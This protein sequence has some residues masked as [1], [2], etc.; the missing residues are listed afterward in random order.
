MGL[1][2]IKRKQRISA[3][4]QNTTWGGDK[5][6]FGYRMLCKM[7]WNEGQGLGKNQDGLTDHLRVQT[8][9]D[10]AGLGAERK[11]AVSAG[12]TYYQLNLFDD[13][14]RR[15]NGTDGEVNNDAREDEQL[16]EK[17]LKE[18]KGRERPEKRRSKAKDRRERS[19]SPSH[20]N[21]IMETAKLSK[22]SASSST[23]PAS[24]RLA[25][26]RKFIQQKLVASYSAMDLRQI[27][28]AQASEG[29]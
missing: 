3:D 9:S 16:K 29:Q 21:K 5:E 20:Q 19:I 22:S 7:G 25:H 18:K 11:P 13:V 6:K 2:G 15:L 27:L 14:L 12:E 26:R 24:G 17:D 28:G 1:A 4:P 8:K 10:T 23:M